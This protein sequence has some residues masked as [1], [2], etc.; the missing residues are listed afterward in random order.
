M[1][2]LQDLNQAHV[3][4]PLIADINIALSGTDNCPLENQTGM[5]CALGENSSLYPQHELKTLRPR[6]RLSGKRYS[7]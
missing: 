3:P 2:L 1:K 5:F 7:A 6:S 4:G